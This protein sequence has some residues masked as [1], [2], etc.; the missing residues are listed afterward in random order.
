MTKT[1]NPSSSPLSRKH[2][3]KESAS[4]AFS[5]AD[6]SK[7]FTI[8][9]FTI[10]KTVGTGSFGRV[11][12]VKLNSTGTYF[13]LK[14][15]RKSDVIKLH[16]VEHI[17]NEKKILAMLDMPFLVG[18][19]AAFQ[20]AGHLYLVLEYVQGG[21]L[22]TFLRR[23]GRFE[24][25]MARFYGAEVTVAFEYLHA[26]HI[27]Y[28][29]LKPEN[30]LIDAKGHIKI[31][32]FGFAKQIKEDQT[33]TLC[34]TPEY[35][36]P[37]I[38]KAKGYGKS[39]DWWALG[40]LIYEMIAGFPPFSDDDNIKLFEK[41]IACKLRFPEGFDKKAK[42]LCKCLITP[43]LSKRYGNLKRGAED[44]K[45]HAW[46]DAIEWDQLVQLGIP[47]PYIPAVSGESDTSNFETYDEDY[48]AYGGTGHDA[49]KDKFDGF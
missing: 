7:E 17:L 14:A 48:T 9:D 10:R 22:F 39:V 23:C 41:I 30:L 5:A 13:A 46:F 32:D 31:T 29:D 20:D 38:I 49:Y 44:V 34:G 43:D 15:L 12:L 3:A 40:I 45:A 42:D 47:A 8:Q 4:S 36:A 11:H 27:A 33:W 21:E 24:N 2:T 16:Q 19:Q 1:V 35:L 28:R 25:N 18:M 37:E 26:R 6:R